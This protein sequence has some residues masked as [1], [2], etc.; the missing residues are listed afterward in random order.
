MSFTPFIAQDSRIADITSRADYALFKG[1]AN[2]TYQSY[3]ST[4]ASSSSISFNI[5]P[6]SEGVVVSR[7]VMI[8]A[9]IKFQVDITNVPLNEVAFSLGESVAFQAFPF[10]SLI[11]TASVSI[12]NTNI[13]TNLLDTRDA[14]LKMIPQKELGKYQDATPALLDTFYKVYP[15]TAVDNS[16]L[17]A[18]AKAS[19]DKEI[20]PRGAWPIKSYNVAKTAGAGQAPTGASL[21]SGGLTDRWVVTIEVD[22]TEPLMVSPFIYGS[23]NVGSEQ[24]LFGVNQL[25]IVLN[26]DASCRRLLSSYNSAYTYAISLDATTPFRA[27]MLVNYLSIQPGECVAARNVVPYLETPRYIT[28][29]TNTPS[30]SA[31]T[32]ATIAASNI[33]LSK[34]P[35]Y[36]MIF[37]RKPMASQTCFDSASFLP[38]TNLSINFNNQSGLLSSATQKDLYKMSVRNGLCQSWTEF[39]GYASIPGT[40]ATRTPSR[41]AT[42]GGVVV[43]NPAFDLSLGPTLVN[44]SSGQFSLQ[45]NATVLNNG[46]AS[47][48]PELVIITVNSGLITTIAGNTS[49]NSGF[50]TSS[51]VMDAAQATKVS[52]TLMTRAVGGS[53]FTALGS[54]LKSIPIVG[55]VVSG[56]GGAKMK[57]SARSAG[58]METYV[59]K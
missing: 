46:T 41:V 26:M 59:Q 1:A 13:S 34:V 16:E 36:I 9:T 53:L 2:S 58:K 55:D 23:P 17:N 54:I 39:S 25:N 32:T 6:P 24:G 29:V 35:D 8:E 30:I 3:P 44:G 51:I 48:T 40:T 21:T 43:C 37:A 7:E 10:N 31:G 45:V 15:S 12:N 57:G 50:I 28:P 33:Q 14:L 38:I 4:S 18:Y 52:R 27:N 5:N 22:V 20:L 49:L 11:Q 56:L 19:Y 47:I 42:V